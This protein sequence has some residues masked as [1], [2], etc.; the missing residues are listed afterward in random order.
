MLLAEQIYS[1]IVL[2]FAVASISWTVTQEELFSEFRGFCT[3]RINKGSSTIVRKFF[4]VFTC[5]YCF[6]HWVA[7]LVVA[8]TQFQTLL[9]DWRGYII[10][11]FVLSWLA[12]QWMSL[13]RHIRVAI[14]Y[15]N[16][17]AEDL[18]DK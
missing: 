8:V 16:S 3:K 14:K 17:L 4:Y 5:E 13:Y 10:S 18:K 9:A 15:E 6:S 2:S 7:L 12:N 11:V 1:L